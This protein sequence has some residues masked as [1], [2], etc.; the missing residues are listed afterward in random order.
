M[1]R[2]FGA[3]L[4]III[5]LGAGGCGGHGGDRFTASELRPGRTFYLLAHDWHA[6]IIVRKADIPESVWPQHQEIKDV[7][8]LEVGWGD[9]DFYQEREPHL[10]L[11]L[12]ALLLPTASVLHVAGRRELTDYFPNKGIVELTV[13]DQDFAELCRYIER[14]YALDERGLP[15]PLGEGLYGTSR[16]YRAR[17][18]YHLC[19]TCNVWTAKALQAAGL[20]INPVLTL[21]VDNL[22]SKAARYGKVGLGKEQINVD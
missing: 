15:Q 2:I 20:Q 10:G 19:R 12:K 22:M 17:N 5:L 8:Y 6:G 18:N 9:A 21:T 3:L 13:D 11:A 14:S 7:E 16:F 1:E 4:L